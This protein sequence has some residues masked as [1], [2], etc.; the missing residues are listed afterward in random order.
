MVTFAVA[1]SSPCAVSLHRTALSLNLARRW[2]RNAKLMAILG[3]ISIVIIVHAAAD[4]AAVCCWWCS[5]CCCLSRARHTPPKPLT[6]PDGHHRLGT[7]PI[8][9]APQ[10]QYSSCSCS[11][12][13]PAAAAVSLF[14]VADE[15]I[16]GKY[17]LKDVPLSLLSQER[18]ALAG[19]SAQFGLTSK[20]D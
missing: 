5:S 14:P 20:V 16:Y 13:S 10:E 17:A 11:S 19:M 8:T 15:F 2:W 3:A 18:R 12:S 9:P 6:N 1:V 4:V 7:Q